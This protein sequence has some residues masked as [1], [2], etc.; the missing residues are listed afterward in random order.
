VAVACLLV[1]AAAPPQIAGASAVRFHVSAQG[2]DHWPG[3][4][5]KPFASLERARNAV[6]ELKRTAGGE[7]KH[8]VEIIAHGELTVLQLLTLA[9]RDSGTKKCPITYKGA[10][11]SKLVGGIVVHGFAPVTDPAVLSLLEESARAKIVQADLKG[12]GITNYGSPGGGGIEVFFN[13]KPMTLARWPNKGFTKIVAVETNKPNAIH[14]RKG[15]LVGNIFYEGDRPSRWLKEQDPWVHGYWFWDWSD[16]R[17]QIESIDPARK[18]IKLKPPYHH[19][20]YRKGQYYY[21]YNLLSEIDSPGEWYVDRKKGVLYFWPPADPAVSRTVVSVAETVIKADGISNVRFE[22]LLVE[23]ARGDAI[24]IANS[25]QVTISDCVV[26]N[27]GGSAIIVSGGDHCTISDCE[28]YNLGRGGISISGGD[29]VTLTPADHQVLRCHI[30]D[31]GR[32]VRMYSAGVAIHGVGNRIAHCRIHDAPHQAIGFGGNDQVIEYNEIFRVC[33]ESNDAGA[34]YA[35]RDWSMLGNMIRYNYLHDIRGFEN[36]GCVG[37]YLDDFFSGTTI[38]GNVFT[39]VSRAAMVGGGNY[40]TIENNLFIDCN[41][42]IHLDARGEGWARS[43]FD[44]SNTELLDKMKAVGYKSAHYAKYPWLATAMDQPNPAH[45][46][47][48]KFDRNVAIGGVWESVEKKARSGN[49]FKDN[50]VTTD[51][52]LLTTNPRTGIPDLTQAAYR[53]TGLKA[54]PTGK[55]GLRD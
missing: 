7:L 27:S 46:R 14:G 53:K 6:R 34:I 17:E 40:N 12:L 29:R 45:P 39:N 41:P 30:H 23:A 13:D 32:I 10:K 22:K 50:T 48:N 52:S 38:Y 15:D 9:Q 5:S 35:G 44:G 21:A 36:K 2:N 24:E 18:L 49:E 16:Q 33:M 19:Y 28:V 51:R 3:T 37:V 1:L 42:C 31:Y 11:D 47:G 55:M 8:P 54:L 43:Y 26:R 20:G 25:R 4:A